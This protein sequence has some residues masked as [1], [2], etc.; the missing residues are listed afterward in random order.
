VGKGV[1]ECAGDGEQ[2]GIAGDVVTGS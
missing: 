1:S 2:R